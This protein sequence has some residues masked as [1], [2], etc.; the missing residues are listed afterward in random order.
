MSQAAYTVYDDVSYDGR[1]FIKHFTGRRLTEDELKLVL[2]KHEAGLLVTGGLNTDFYDDH[3]SVGCINQHV[4][5]MCMAQ[6]AFAM[7]IAIGVWFD[8]N[9][10]R[11]WSK[12]EFEFELRK[13]NFV[14]E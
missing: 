14:E 11:H 2:D 4:Y 8:R 7:N 13:M 12:G 1:P 9:Y 5:R 3:K 10:Q 6:D